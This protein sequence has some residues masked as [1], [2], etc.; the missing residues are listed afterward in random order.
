M[1]IDNLHS[2]IAQMDRVNREARVLGIDQS[3]AVGEDRVV[4][5]EDARFVSDL[6][7]AF[8]D[9][10]GVRLDVVEQAR[11]DLRSGQL[12]SEDDYQRTI[13]ALMMEL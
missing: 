7:D 13:D 9:L 4:L 10:E 2:Q 12:G 8:G 3:R 1:K 6:Q 5:S 11:A